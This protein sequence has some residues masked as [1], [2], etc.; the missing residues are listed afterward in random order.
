MT[1][2]RVN[3]ENGLNQ[4]KAL[5]HCTF[6]RQVCPQGQQGEV[7]D[8]GK[9]LCDN[10]V[11]MQFIVLSYRGNQRR[12]KVPDVETILPQCGGSSWVPGPV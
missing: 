2:N 3:Q 4:K 1:S 8:V 11:G 6:R 9:A 12:L 5:R 10:S 7:T